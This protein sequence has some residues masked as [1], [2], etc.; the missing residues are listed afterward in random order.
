MDNKV[1]M[2]PNS[3]E[4][5][6]LDIMMILNRGL[7]AYTNVRITVDEFVEATRKFIFTKELDVLTLDAMISEFTEPVAVVLTLENA[8]KPNFQKIIMNKS[9][10]PIQIDTEFYSLNLENNGSLTLIYTSAW[11]VTSSIGA[12]TI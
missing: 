7:T 5:T 2:L 8:V 1:S 11:T 3:E 10:S 6:P 9:G 4:V 12:S